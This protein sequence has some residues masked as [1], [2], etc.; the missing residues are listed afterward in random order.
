VITM[1]RKDHIRQL[2]NNF[3]TS[4]HD[5]RLEQCTFGVE[6]ETQV[7]DN[8]T[9]FWDTVYTNLDREDYMD[10]E[11]YQEE[12]NDLVLEHISDNKL[13]DLLPHRIWGHRFSSNIPFQVRRW[14]GRWSAARSSDINR[15]ILKA[16]RTQLIAIE[17]QLDDP[18]DN[19][20]K[21]KLFNKYCTP[22][23]D[24]INHIEELDEQLDYSIEE[25]CRESMID[26]DYH[27]DENTIR[28]NNP[29]LFT[30]DL[31]CSHDDIEIVGDQSVSGKELRTIGGLDR[32]E[33][34]NATKAI[35]DGIED[36][37]HYV[38]RDCS[39][40]IHIK[41]GDI[42]HYYGD[43][44]LHNAIMEYLIFNLDRL[45]K[46]VQQRLK[47]GGNRWIKPYMDN[48]KYRW[49][50]FHDQGT[51]EFRLFGNIDNADD[52]FQ[53]QQIA[54]ESLAYGYQ[55]RFG[56]YERALSNNDLVIL[57]EGA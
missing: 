8:R 24:R 23:F 17:D 32:H 50:N 29:E 10:T 12:L 21:V 14:N 33:F 42:R 25:G 54:L 41:L 11:A 48:N 1:E 18:N 47:S 44:K 16:I 39:A 4:N 15:L 36:S 45:P 38:D 56:D 53:C 26:S 40:H 13:S 30:S 19:D 7:D 3:I 55:V 46:S 2:I 27:L 49:V 28:R 57:A 43:G 31:S 34:A 51:I 6:I 35:F 37:D 22:F 5:E 9:D 20:I 52:L